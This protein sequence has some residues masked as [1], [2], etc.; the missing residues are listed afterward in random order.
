M[1]VVV[2]VKRPGYRVM[3][4][5]IKRARIPRRHRTTKE[6]VIEYLRNNFGVNIVK[7]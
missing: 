1:D 6:E 7:E 4:R 2:T 3:N 5:R